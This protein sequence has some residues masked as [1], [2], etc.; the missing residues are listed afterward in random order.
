MH[1]FLGLLA[2]LRT[3]QCNCA[4]PGCVAQQEEIDYNSKANSE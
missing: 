2:W 4:I 1:L 3:V